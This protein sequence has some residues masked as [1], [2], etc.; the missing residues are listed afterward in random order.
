MAHPARGGGY[1][2][3]ATYQVG[4]TGSCLERLGVEGDT[5]GTVLVGFDFPIGLPRAYAHVV[6][7]DSFR[8]ALPRFGTGQWSRFYEVCRAPDQVELRRPFFPNSC[9]AKGECT[10][11]HLEAGLQLAKADLYRQCEL[12]TEHKGPASPLFWTLGAK[13][14]GKGAISGWQE[15]IGPMLIAGAALWPFDGDL[16]ELLR[17]S[18][19]VIVETY[20]A[21]FYVLLGLHFLPGKGNGKT[22]RLARQRLATDV[23]ERAAALGV[24][25]SGPARAEIKDGFG[26][27][28]DGEDRFDAMVGLLG[29]L[30]HLANAGEGERLPERDVVA[31]E[32]WML[33]QPVSTP[34]PPI[35][36][37]G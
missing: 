36:E 6:G 12:R 14:V 8:E 30:T 11:K 1:D 37:S 23:L 16:P 34:T 3:D 17:T 19:C 31:V 25:L 13:Q 28:R 35:S 27:G 20:P 33:G 32:G 10:W 5:P 4:R 18:S 2:V 9:R 29:M 24:E 21:E 22:S 26:E 7:I 15:F